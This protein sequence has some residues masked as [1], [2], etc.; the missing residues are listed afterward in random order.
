M[1]SRALVP[2]LLSRYVWNIRRP[3]VHPPL[4]RLLSR[5]RLPPFCSPLSASCN[6]NPNTDHELLGS[7][8]PSHCATYSTTNTQ[9]SSTHH[10]YRTV[11]RQYRPRH[12]FGA[13][14]LSLVQS[15]LLDFNS[16]SYG[17]GASFSSFPYG[18]TSVSQVP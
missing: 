17:L 7:S 15:V 3:H 18:V 5:L 6:A 16:R 10:P 1:A 14:K 4:P 9:C 8:P 11:S 13:C 2:M 12:Q